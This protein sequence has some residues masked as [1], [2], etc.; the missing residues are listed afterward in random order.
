[1][2]MIYILETILLMIFPLFQFYLESWQISLSATTCTL[3]LHN[4]VSSP[5]FN[6]Q[7][8]FRPSGSITAALISILQH[9]TSLLSG[10]HPHV[11]LIS[12]DFS[13]AFDSVRH[14]SLLNKMS[15]LPVPDYIYNWISS[16]LDSSS[17]CTL[18][19]KSSFPP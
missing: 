5:L 9:I 12:L 17:H 18:F 6:D 19:Q 11:I 1:M 16:Y 2:M 4:L 7:F 10:G 14:S 3:F 13:K 8:A 15:S